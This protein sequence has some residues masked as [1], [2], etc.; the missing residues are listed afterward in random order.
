MRFDLTDLR[1]FLH[2]V[3]SGSITGGA[4]KA[5]M[6][7]PSASAR[8]RGME[9]VIGLPLLE[10]GR[11]GVE[12][13]PAGVTLVHHARL[14][15]R[16]IEAMHGELG[17][18]SAGL[19]GQVRLLTN[20]GAMTE[21]LPR[22]LAGFLAAHPAVDIDLKE[23]RSV[24]IVKAV[25]A[26][27]ADLGFISD[28]VDPG[29]LYVEPF[30]LDRL[31]L[32][33]AKDNSLAG[34]RRIAFAEALDFPFVGLSDNSPLQLL[35][36]DHASRAG[37]PL[38]VRVRLPGFGAIC[39]LVEAGVGVA[40]LPE[41][42]VRRRRRSM[43]LASLVLSD[44]WAVRRLAFCYRDLAGLPVHARALATHLRNSFSN[45]P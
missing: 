31:V 34:Q 12:P 19:R 28:A 1:L 41:A 32:A 29:I 2:V 21:F 15:L 8:L 42:A 43:A 17:E 3:E 7:L 6:A 13:T 11:R 4:E 39:R 36:D 20:T 26:G 9:E 14:V 45:T 37:R 10:R 33:V 38:N 25:T 24:D 30:A 18:F 35:I 44:P 23:R 27:S 22:A 5:H 16:Q 40:V